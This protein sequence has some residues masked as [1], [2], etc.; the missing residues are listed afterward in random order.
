MEKSK[1]CR[2]TMQLFAEAQL[3]HKQNAK[4]NMGKCFISDQER[5]SLKKFKSY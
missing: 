5:V 1:F 3:S 4:M 2:G